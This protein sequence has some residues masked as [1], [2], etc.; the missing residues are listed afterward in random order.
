M[1]LKLIPQISNALKGI[2][3]PQMQI[4]AN[5]CS[6]VS[7]LNDFK[8]EGDSDEPIEM[9]NP[10]EKEKVKCILCRN[11]IEPSYKNVQLLSQFQSPY[12]GR[13]YGR[14]ITGLCKNMQEK[15]EMSIMRAQHLGFMGYVTKQPRFLKDPKLFNPEK[16]QR[17][18]KY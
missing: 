13:T 17:P 6:Q 11:N 4:S 12:T 2:K 8:N 14:H 5:F 18:H 7:N 1:F 9:K 10:F 3:K 16:P 15:V